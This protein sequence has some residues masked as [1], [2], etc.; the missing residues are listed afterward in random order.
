M[1]HRDRRLVDLRLQAGARLEGLGCQEE[2]A[3]DAGEAETRARLESILG[4]AS[5]REGG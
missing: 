2:T 3:R 4:R 5:A 1:P